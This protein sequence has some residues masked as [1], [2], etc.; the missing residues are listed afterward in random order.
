MRRTYQYAAVTK[1]EAQRRRWTFYE[2]V[3]FRFRHLNT[4]DQFWRDFYKLLLGR[5]TRGGFI[6]I[7]T[8]SDEIMMSLLKISRDKC[9][10]HGKI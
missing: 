6:C 8:E 10:L 5:D 7:L 9:S 1:D 2:A 3:N 4:Y